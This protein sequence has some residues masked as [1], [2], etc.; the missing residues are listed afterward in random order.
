MK[1]LIIDI[2]AVLIICGSAFA[3]PDTLWTKTFGG[4]DDDWGESVQQTSDGGYIIA[5]TTE[6]YGAG[7]RDVYLIKTDGEGFQ[8]WYQTFGGVSWDYGESVQ[9]T[10]DGGY[11]IVGYTCSYGA[12]SYDVYLIKTNA[13]GNQQWSQTFGGISV[14]CGYSVQQTSDG[15]YIIAGWTYSFGAGYR[16]VYLIKTDANG[17]ETWSQI[18]GGSDDDIGRSV[19]QTSDG[20]YIIAGYTGPYAGTNDVYLIKTDANGNEQWSQVFGGSYSDYGRSVQQTSDGG[21]IIAGWTASYGAGSYDVYMIRLES[22]IAS[23]VTLTLTPQNPPIQI[24]AGGGSFNFD[25]EIDNGTTTN[26]TVDVSTDVTLPGGTTYPILSRYGIN[27]TSGASII[28][29]LTQF[30]PGG[31][32]LG[33]YIYNGYVYDHNTWELLAEDSFPFEKLAGD[34]APNHNLGW[35]LYGWEGEGAPAVSIPIEYATISIY[36]NPFNAETVISFQL[37]AAS[38]LDLTL[39]DITGREVAK[40]HDGFIEAGYHEVKFDAS[41]LSSGIYF[42]RLTAGEFSGMKKMILVK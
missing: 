33:N 6:S 26:Y 16:D 5:G 22:E 12:G 19:Q 8:Q 28:R 13:E 27:L 10:S 23:T 29:N 2:T 7:G 34:D 9:Q 38:C 41:Q 1:Q 4:S 3:Q 17:N 30:I 11:I 21:Y 40:L 37:Q 15:G 20:G 31:T 36:P 42:A 24:P 35:A 18:F 25:M 14:D 32:P 39:Y